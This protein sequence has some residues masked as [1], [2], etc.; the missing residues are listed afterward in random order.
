M[1]RTNL[2]DESSIGLRMKVGKSPVKCPCVDPAHDQQGEA[3]DRLRA[4]SSKDTQY[5]TEDYLSRGFRPFETM[6]RFGIDSCSFKDC[7]EPIDE[8]CRQKMVDWAFRVSDHFHTSREIVSYAFSFLDRFVSRC[9]CDRTAFKL[10]SMTSLYMAIKLFNPKQ[11]SIH[12]LSDLSRGEFTFDHIAE[13]ERVIL[14][15]L[16]WMLNPPTIQSF[17]GS[18]HE[19]I[20]LDDPSLLHA[21]Y[22]RATFFSELALYDYALIVERRL[23]LAIASILNA[24]EGIDDSAESRKT[25]QE[26]IRSITRAIGADFNLDAIDSIQGRLWYLY[27]C[28][29]QLHEDDASSHQASMCHVTSKGSETTMGRL[30]HSPVSVQHSRHF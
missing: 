12:S 29:A 11:I 17:I 8:T 7:Q 16:D 30:A 24:I 22:Q 2:P 6:T 10:A 14:K 5:I 3:T 23:H 4:L 18:L 25:Q 1:T 26:F 28:S 15:T 20:P 21:V 27:S 19:Y 13:M 9:T